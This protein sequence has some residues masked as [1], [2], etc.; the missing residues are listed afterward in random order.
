MDVSDLEKKA[1]AEILQATQKRA[2]TALFLSLAASCIIILM[3]FNLFES[4]QLRQ[5]DF[6]RGEDAKSEYQK[7][8]TSHVADMSYYQLPALGIQISCEDVGLFG[9]LALLI[10]SLYSMMA[11]S[12]LQCHVRCATKEPFASSRIVQTLLETENPPRLP[13]LVPFVLRLL[14]L[15]PFVACAF[16][17]WYGVSGHFPQLPANDPLREVFNAI[18]SRALLFDG[19]GVFF[20]LL[21]LACNWK[22]FVLAH[23]T[24]KHIREHQALKHQESTGAAAGS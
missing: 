14:V 11:F 4:H 13:R 20:S 3:I 19:I 1:C 18:R 22:T 2:R 21:V 9:P 6:I 23:G 15:L 16:V 10:F 8:I 17:G 12:A 24:A 7:S 5:T